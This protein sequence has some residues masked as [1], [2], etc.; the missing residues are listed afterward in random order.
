[1]TA[2]NK[3]EDDIA[4]ASDYFN[5]YKDWLTNEQKLS[6][7]V[8]YEYH[9]IAKNFFR[10]TKYKIPPDNIGESIA[11]FLGSIDNPNHYN[12]TLAALKKLFEFIGMPDTLKD[13]KNKKIMPSF[14]RK[15]PDKDDMI[16]FG[17]AI[18]NKK[19]Q[20]YYYISVVS[21]MRPEHVLRIRKNLFDTRHR[22]INTW[23]K[24]F[25]NKNFFFAFYTEELKPLI[26]EHLSTIAG[27]DLVFDLGMRY[28]Q[29]EYCK[30]SEETGIKITPK[31][32]RK[33][34]T[35]YLKRNPDYRMIN[36]DVNL[37]TSHTPADVVQKWYQD[38]DPLDLK[39]EFDKATV[40]L[41][42]LS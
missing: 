7:N 3:P 36:D 33:F 17:K 1:M 11:E 14:S 31:T 21:A 27:N 13:Y 38:N 24:E 29:K 25:S 42:L 5:W 39:N 15:A 22:V 16:A 9:R 35:T 37:I 28:L 19:V 23:M 32:P 4:F 20:L 26:E 8:I 34:M 41:K 30:V 12:N 2:K 10:F 40:N 18:K 6:P